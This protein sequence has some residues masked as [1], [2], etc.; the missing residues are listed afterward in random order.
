MK[1][2][3]PLIALL[4]CGASTAQ[5]ATRGPSQ[6]IGHRIALQ[7][8][9]TEAQL[10][11]HIS[12]AAVAR[13]FRTLQTRVISHSAV[14]LP[15]PAR[16]HLR[17]LSVSRS[18]LRASGGDLGL[19]ATVVAAGSGQQELVGPNTGDFSN[20]HQVWTGYQS[21]VQ[22]DFNFEPV[23]DLVY[24][25][26]VFSDGSSAQAY[27]NDSVNLLGPLDTAGTTDCSSSI[28]SFCKIIGFVSQEGHLN[29]YSIGVVNQCVIETGGVGDPA[30]MN[31]N[32]NVTKLLA[33]TFVQG[34]T[35]A[36]QA[37][38]TSSTQPQPQLQPTISVSDVG[39]AHLVK[40]NAKITTT[41]KSGEKGYF[42]LDFTDANEGSNTPSATVK[43]DKS[44][45]SQLGGTL[46][47]TRYQASDGTLFFGL[48]HKF[49]TKKLLHL[50]AKF[51]ISL[52]GAQDES[53]LSFSVKAAPKKKH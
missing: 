16:N 28:G 33:D 5:A 12:L 48:T 39:L 40:G 34:V 20:W 27:A 22:A 6:A 13:S 10:R 53:S 17:P 32:P 23:F 24:R 11:G 51:T 4:L 25:G 45:G 19:P 35:E 8:L 9:R 41:L 52:G 31:A 43:F 50:T 2:L 49:K 37:C 1:R 36:Q 42:I 7:T 15:L 38:T 44:N 29:L 14:D 26:N 3:I 46:T 21:G 18:P 30:A 47:M